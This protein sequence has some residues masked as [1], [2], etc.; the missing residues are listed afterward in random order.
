[1]LS[2]DVESEGGNKGQGDSDPSSSQVCARA[3]LGFDRR[4]ASPKVS[5]RE[6]NPVIKSNLRMQC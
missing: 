3:G 5:P 1:M 4:P 2:L 6:A